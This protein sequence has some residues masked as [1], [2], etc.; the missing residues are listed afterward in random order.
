[1]KYTIDKLKLFVKT[2]KSKLHE[3]ALYPMA[4]E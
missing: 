2:K 3:L 4:E 1:M